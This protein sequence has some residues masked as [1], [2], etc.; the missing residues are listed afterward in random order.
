MSDIVVWLERFAAEIGQPAPDRAQIDQILE[1]AGVA[2]H[3]SARQAAP[4]ACWMAGVAGLDLTDAIR[5][6]EKLAEETP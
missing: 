6:A 1:L 2:A 5:I 3:A 4:V